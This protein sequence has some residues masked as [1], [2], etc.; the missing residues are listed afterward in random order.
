MLT[1]QNR[2]YK[3]YE[4]NGF[5]EVDRINFDQYR[6]EC[7]EEIEKSKQNDLLKLGTTLADKKHG[8]K[9]VLENC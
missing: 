6:K 9:D 1:K 3:K 4:N 8:T 5:R 7:N 2:K